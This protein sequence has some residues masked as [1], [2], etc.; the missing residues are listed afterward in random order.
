MTTAP[1]LEH[2]E[3]IWGAISGDTGIAGALLRLTVRHHALAVVATTLVLAAAVYVAIAGLLGELRGGAPVSMREVL[4]FDVI[5][6]GALG[7]GVLVGR[8]RLFRNRIS[9]RMTWRTILS[10]ALPV[11]SDVL[12]WAH[13]GD[14]RTA[15]MYAMLVL[16]AC[17][18]IGSLL[19]LPGL[20]LA[21]TLP[22]VA[23]IVSAAFPPATVVAV[24]IAETAV[25]L[26][27]M[28]HV[29]EHGLQSST[30]APLS[31]G[32]GLATHVP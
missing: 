17:M 1:T 20:W 28:R 9:Q 25:L 24:T 21:A 32:R 11:V 4:G 19:L 31:P 8:K 16:A 27:V 22:L 6:A 14:S 18:S 29:L 30:E 26:V 5:L 23:A 12:T 15:G 3:Q 2:F 7:L 10:L 13:G